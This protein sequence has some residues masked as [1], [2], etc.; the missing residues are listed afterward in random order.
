MAATCAGVGE[1][2]VRP[3]YESRLAAASA[4]PGATSQEVQAAGGSLRL[5]VACLRGFRKL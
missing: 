1:F 4:G 2:Q 3:S 5:A